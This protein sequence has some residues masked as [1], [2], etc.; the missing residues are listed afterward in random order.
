MDILGSMLQQNQWLKEWF[1]KT[2]C[3][4]GRAF[5]GKSSRLVVAIDLSS[6]TELF[7]ERQTLLLIGRS[8][9]SPIDFVRA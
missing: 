4:T 1:N 6:P 2:N 8:N 5:Y 3:S 9:I 7:T